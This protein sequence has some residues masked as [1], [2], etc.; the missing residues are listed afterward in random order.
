M[1]P[2]T[3]SNGR[4]PPG[5][6]RFP[7]FDVSWVGDGP[8]ADLLCFGSEDGRLRLAAT[9]NLVA[10]ALLL[11]IESK[12]AINGA[13]FYGRS[14]AVSTRNEVVLFKLSAT[15]DAVESQAVCPAG[16]HGVIA[17]ASGQF[18]APLGRNGLLV[19][20]PEI[21]DIK[22]PVIFS[23]NADDP[24]YFYRVI[25]LNAAGCSEILVSATRSGG[26]A[27]TTVPQRNGNAGT[28]SFTFPGLDII[29][30]CA[31]DPDG[32]LAVAALGVDCTL[33]FSRDVQRDRRPLTLR[34]NGVQG[35]AYGLLCARGHL[36]LL[37]SHGLYILRGLAR[38]F[39]EG[40]PVGR[41][42]TAV[43]EIPLE[44]VDANLVHDR[45]LFIVMADHT[46]LYDVEQLVGRE[47]NGEAHG[48]DQEIVPTF[49]T[50]D[51]QSREEA[52]LMAVG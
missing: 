25:S 38:R 39:L 7:D 51:W 20:K 48:Y 29:D 12:E 30:V 40:E 37:T 4:L 41:Q 17:A 8:T 13:A 15:M 33:V 43:S 50:P 10:G 28:S 3:S 21:G 9:K 6:V 32:G 26:V 36:F 2:I 5:L 27:A 44:A 31:L 45:W 46:L 16:A 14:G 19:W 24:Y 23:P 35:T 49:L 1:T 11:A 47:S 52:T 42:P 22:A 34:L 18:V